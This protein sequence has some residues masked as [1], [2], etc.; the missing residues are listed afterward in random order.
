M[1]LIFALN[2]SFVI[3]MQIFITNEAQIAI[4]LSHTKWTQTYTRSIEM[5][6]LTLSDV[7]HATSV[8]S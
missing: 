8:N 7:K 4:T 6:F 2:L 5:N 3:G 1:K